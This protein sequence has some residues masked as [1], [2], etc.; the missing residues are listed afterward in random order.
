MGLNPE[1]VLGSAATTDIYRHLFLVDAHSRLCYIL[2]KLVSGETGT[3]RINPRMLS[4]A[5][6]QGQ[7]QSLRGLILVVQLSEMLPATFIYTI[8]LFGG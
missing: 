3:T 1:Q 4:C 6:G 8:A 2:I 7:A 5:F